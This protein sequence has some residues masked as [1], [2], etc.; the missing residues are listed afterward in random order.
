MNEH[1]SLQEKMHTNLS[2]HNM[3]VMFVFKKEVFF[4]SFNH[5][6]MSL[7]YSVHRGNISSISKGMHR[8]SNQKI[9]ILRASFSSETLCSI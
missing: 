6:K 8:L 9:C 1:N 7:L 2:K 3:V 5:V 4:K